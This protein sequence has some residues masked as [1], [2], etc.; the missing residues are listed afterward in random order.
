[1][2]NKRTSYCHLHKGKRYGR[3]YRISQSEIIKGHNFSSHYWMHDLWPEREH[4]IGWFIDRFW[5]VPGWPEDWKVAWYA[6]D[7]RRRQQP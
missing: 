3:M 2:T 4:D 1:M 5:P 6:E 7:E